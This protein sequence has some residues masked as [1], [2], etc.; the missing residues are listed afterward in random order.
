MG[1]E[2]SRGTILAI[3]DERNIRHLIR[4]ELGVEGFEVTTAKTGEEGLSI[5]EKRHFDVLLLD[6]R[7]PE[8]DGLQVL[9]KIRGRVPRPEVIMITGYGDIETAVESMKLGARDY[10]TKPFKLSELLAL[11]NQIIDENN[12]LNAGARRTPDG[13]G[14]QNA[15]FVI[16][17]SPTMREVYDLL[18]RVAATDVTV[19]IQGETGVGKDVLA[20]QVH[21]ASPR[22]DRP[23]VVVD[24]GLL[25]ENLAESEL[26]GH[27]KG[28]F[29][30][31]NESKKGLVEES[32]TG[33]IFFDEIGNIELEMQKK[34]LRFLETKKFRRL[35]ETREREVDS[36][37]VLATNVNLSE[38][39]AK[40]TLRKDLFYRMDV[41]CIPVPPL[42]EHPGDVGA[43]ARYFLDLSGFDEARKTISPD[44]MTVL[45]QYGWPGNIRELRSVVVKAA[46]LSKSRVIERDDLPSHMLARSRHA[47]AETDSKSLEDLE[48]EHIMKVL[49]DTGG[50]QSQAAQILGINRKTL[51]K[52]IHKHGLFR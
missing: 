36:R 37:I 6:I 51:Y 22:R 40:G 35:G 42:R 9:R 34:F 43:L 27:T 20:R 16:C 41:I 13:A 52:K 21:Y 50:N 45:K 38:A 15:R 12:R 5:L 2:M 7:L 48:K 47:P 24:C 1:F 39:A 18:E 46:V 30:G 33:T 10:I 4:N 29:S 19:L 11:I 31:A 25:N 14:E 49:E 8:M 28:A 26:Y 32:H 17:P 44:A 23:L 3:D